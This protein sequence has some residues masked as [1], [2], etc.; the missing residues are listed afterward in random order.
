MSY[1]VFVYITSIIL[2][3]G[4]GI[5]IFKKYR[6]LSGLFFFLFTVF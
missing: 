2:S 4:C 5:L 3:I 6:N 1:Y